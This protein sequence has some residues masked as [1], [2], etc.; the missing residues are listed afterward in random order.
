MFGR[1]PRADNLPIAPREA[2]KSAI[3]TGPSTHEE[4][5]DIMMFHLG[6][7]PGRS[8]CSK[9]MTGSQMAEGLYQQKYVAFVDMLGFSNLVLASAEDQTSHARIIEAIERLKDTACDNPAIGMITTYFSDC[10]VLSC[11]R[12]P[13]GLAE[14]LQNLT[15]I[16]EN[17]LVVDVL[18]RG[19][20]TVGAVH[21]DRQFLFGP[22]MLEAYRME[23]GEAIHPTILLNP[24]ARADIEAAG[25]EAYMVHDEPEPERYYLHYLINF[26][27]Y[28]PTPRAGVHILDGPALLVRH[29]IARRIADDGGSPLAKALWLERYWNE[30]VGVQGHLGMVDRAADLAIPDARPFRSRRF[31]AG[32]SEG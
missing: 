21:H 24:T 7:V 28:D 9:R 3:L 4:T 32:G 25:F 23:C 8:T 31:I 2:E 22:A 27:L 26:A 6:I 5:W 1:P 12:S 19:G 18:A 13:R 20:L 14:M 15:I 16:V 29:Y 10:I 30:T 17:L 11:E